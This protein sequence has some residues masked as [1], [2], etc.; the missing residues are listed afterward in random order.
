MINKLRVRCI[1][2]KKSPKNKDKVKMS[3]KHTL[4]KNPPKTYI[5]RS[6][7]KSLKFNHFIQELARKRRKFEIIVRGKAIPKGSQKIGPQR[8]ITLF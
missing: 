3:W 8:T 6:S 2:E 5:I 7:S 4:T 1:T